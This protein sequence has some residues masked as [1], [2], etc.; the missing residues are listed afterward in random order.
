MIKTAMILFLLAI[1]GCSSQPPSPP[2]APEPIGDYSPVNPSVINL[3]D[4]KIDL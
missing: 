2:P 4:L 3:S 1:S